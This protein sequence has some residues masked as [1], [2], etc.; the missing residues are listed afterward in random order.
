MLQRYLDDKLT[1]VE[2]MAMGR[3]AIPESDRV[4]VA[5]ARLRDFEKRWGKPRRKT[6]RRAGFAPKTKPYIPQ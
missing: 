3:E 5:D 4:A 6:V 2:A 1:S